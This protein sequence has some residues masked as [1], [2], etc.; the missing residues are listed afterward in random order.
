MRLTADPGCITAAASLRRICVSL[1]DSAIITA[2]CELGIAM[3]GRNS[4]FTMIGATCTHFC[5]T[6]IWMLLRP[7]MDN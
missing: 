5:D 6:S 1:A 2:K 7:S 3:C 4:P